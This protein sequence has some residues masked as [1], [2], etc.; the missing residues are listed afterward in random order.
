MYKIV[1]LKEI[2]PE[3]N[4]KKKYQPHNRIYFYT[5]SMIGTNNLMQGH[6]NP[7]GQIAPPP[8]PPP[9]RFWQII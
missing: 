8:P 4:R 2:F 1:A 3:L 7:G 6:R 9:P 5:F